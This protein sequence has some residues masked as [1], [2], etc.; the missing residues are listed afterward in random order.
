[1]LTFALAWELTRSV[2]YLVMSLQNIYFATAVS[3]LLLLGAALSNSKREGRV[4]WLWVTHQDMMRSC[5]IE[6]DGV[7]VV[8]EGCHG[9]IIN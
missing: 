2:A 3:K 4:A 8:N 1:M 7:G 5:A 9:D 6:E